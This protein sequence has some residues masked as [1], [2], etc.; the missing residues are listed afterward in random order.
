MSIQ[1]ADEVADALASRT[2]VVALESTIF[3]P[4]GLPAP[5]NEAALD[6]CIAAVRAQRRGS[7][8]HRGAR[9]SRAG[10]DSK[11]PNTSAS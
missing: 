2:P 10:S 11:S 5:A 9:R 3:S 1:V 8:G 6:R 4:F 7:R